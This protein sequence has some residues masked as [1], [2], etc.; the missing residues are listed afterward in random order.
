MN[1][2]DVLIYAHQLSSVQRVKSL[3][4][5]WDTLL[6][7]YSKAENVVKLLYEFVINDTELQ[8]AYKES[9]FWADWRKTDFMAIIR[10][11]ERQ[12]IVKAWNHI[13]ILIE[14]SF[15]KKV[16]IPLCSQITT[17]L[18]TVKTVQKK[19]SEW[20]IWEILQNAYKH[21]MLHFK[22]KTKYNTLKQWLMLWN[23]INSNIQNVWDS[24]IM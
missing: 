14:D 7:M 23:I 6:Q 24:L 12:Q 8:R 4:K 2:S 11:K 15:F 13:I 3:L 22:R 20:D 5:L 9:S 17:V 16:L 1:F 21:I 10:Q 18:N 19:Y